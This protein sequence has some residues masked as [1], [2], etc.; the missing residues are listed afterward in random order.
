M[1]GP[2]IRQNAD[3]ES[4][5]SR[6]LC[7]LNKM[8]KMLNEPG[9]LDMMLQQACEI[10]PEAYPFPEY[11]SVNITFNDKSYR[12][13]NYKESQWLER[14]P[15]E[16]PDH[17]Q[18]KLE[19]FFSRDFI[20]KTEKEFLFGDNSFTIHL[21]TL[22]V[23]AISKNHLGRLIY[24]HTERKKELKG[25]RRTAE[26]LKKT[27]SLQESLQEVC[28]FLPD[29]WQFPES[30]VAR[31][32]FG[33]HV[34]TS[35]GF[36]ETPWS[37]R[38]DFETPDG[39]NGS[40]E[41][42]YLDE[43]PPSFE[44]PFLKEERDLLNN[45]AL[46][47]SGTA[48]QRALQELLYFNTERLKELHGLNETSSILRQGRSM[49]ESLQVICSIL[50]DA[51]QYPDFTVARITYGPHVFTSLNFRE[52][53]WVQRQEIETPNHMK[54]LIEVFYLKEFSLADE[55]PFLRE[56]RNMLINMAGLIT[57]S[58]IKR[59]FDNLLHENKERVKELHVIN[60]TSEIITQGMPIEET[61]QKI[62]NI[63]HKSWQYPKHTAVR[64]TYEEKR[65]VNREFT[66]TQWVQ[67][68]NFI[69]IDNKKGSIEVF[70]LKEFPMEYEGPF[71]REERQLI[72]N[73]GRLLSGYLNNYKGREIYSKIKYK[74]I[75]PF[76]PEE[77][78]QSLVKNKQPL[79]LFFNQQTLD[80]YIYLDMMKYKVKEILFVATLY[81][82]FTLEK[83]DGFFEQ[84]M[85]IIYQYSLF[86][87][88]RI[89]GVTSSEEALEMLETSHFDL[90]I[91]MVGLDKE[92]PVLIS[93]QIKQ[94]RPNLLIYML[95]N[96]KSNIQYYEELVP[97]L[98][99]VD[100]LFVW[101][102]ASQIFFAI[103]KS[104]E[105]QANVEND[106]RIG[107]VRV[108]LLIEDSAMYY[109][110]YLQMLYSIVFGQVQQV[111][112]EVEKNELDKICRMRS[113]PKI[114]LARNYDD[115]M[116]IFEKYKDF[117][118]CVISDVEFERDG[119]MDKK[120]GIK[121]IEYIQSQVINLPIILQSSDKRN[122]HVA[123]KLGVS[124][125]NKNSETLLN[126][127]KNFLT[128]YLGFGDFIFRNNEGE[129]IAVAR[130]L[131]EFEALL[132]QVSDESFYLHASENQY[133]LWLMARGEI[134]LARTLNPLRIGD[135]KDVKESRKQLI[136]TIKKYKEEKKRGKVLGFDE[137]A[138]L[139]E[140]N[141]VTFSGGSF[142]G[143]GRGLAF[144]N[145]LVYNLDFSDVDKAINIRTPKTVIIGTDEF[146]Y[147]IERNNLLEVLLN[148]R[149]PYKEIRHH[150]DRA[151]LSQG[152]LRKLEFFIDQV[153]KPIAVRS[154]SLSEDSLTQPFAGIF[155][156]YIIPNTRKDKKS[157]LKYL[158]KAIKLVFASIYSDSSKSYFK[159][160]H[161]KVEEEKM[162][163]VLQELVGNQ[164]G[165]FYYPHISGVAQSYNY[166]PVAH[167]KPEEGFAVAAVG[168][169]SY[170]VEGWKSYRFSPRY[171]NIEMYTTKDLINSSQVQ[172]Y[173]LDCSKKD[174]DYINEGELASLVMLEI[175]E[176]EKHGTINHCVSVYNSINDQIEPG[177]SS[178]G[179]RIV[180]FADILKYKH[181]PLSQTLDIMLGTIEE[182]LGSPVEIE[183]AVDLNRTL[184]DLP[185][186]YLLQIKPLVGNQL[187]INVDFEKLD[188]SKFMLYTSSSLGNG[189]NSHIRDVIFIDIQRF[190]KLKTHE[191]ASEM[192]FINN[193]MV[194]QNK[195]YILIG[196]GRWGTRDPF[197]G[198]PVI[199]S[200][201]SNAKVIV[202]ISLANYPLD[203]SLGSHFFHNVTSMNIGYF[204]V[205]DSSKTD[206]INWNILDEQEI[207][208]ETKFI[209]HIRFANPLTVIMSGKKKTAAIL[210]NT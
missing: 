20:T 101:S 168:L 104:I 156:T 181:I 64:I 80:K 45:L 14:Q 78:R 74:E 109:S 155:D 57:G 111:L 82:A 103:V 150:F 165:R 40:I 175:S 25:I 144:I 163:I 133:S 9:T 29:A 28:S 208:Q 148:P 76:K 48:S 190:N 73:I 85:G 204:S 102:G 125:L 100:K 180:N 209:K 91:I 47:I 201:I 39:K 154:S 115:A 188:K 6:R 89:T 81:D 116:Y 185:S 174:V 146:D 71:L 164:Y 59:V 203:S 157:V 12:N 138:T 166:Y 171:P 17:L 199:W 136:D 162:A 110:K 173:A 153:E 118:L 65:Y 122:E 55:G 27:A 56:E 63:L 96:Y 30:T 16:T 5:D 127:L 114:L 60:Q 117:M 99:S 61:L 23:G 131:R 83:E 129:Q 207:I 189:E 169:G 200:Q 66:E 15:F 193:R 113:R 145:S 210:F 105:D 134:E 172:F 52:T 141:I 44:G 147:F 197:L 108:I 182:A 10:I 50:P 79:Q 186:F 139:D 177:L 4:T 95:L 137:T 7:A 192:E 161:H 98:K 84:F 112:P 49:E 176:A 35:N 142:G 53:P 130:S 46:L 70:Y 43:F 159:A 36:K 13:K 183:Y 77:Y 38:Q 67:R 75:L 126:D 170:V 93:E 206:F 191:M 123:K 194:K 33:D 205:L 11:V 92:T 3:C 184:K 149:I 72:I 18:G 62:A 1:Q 69:T 68:E 135:F 88:P 2:E 41:I 37:Q 8:V 94:K 97:T 24:D 19:I 31:I 202:E 121:F 128:Y 106:T 26:T 187:G 32:T 178:A 86:S 90:V 87:L 143:K 179:P 42:F 167:M 198:I 22:I 119:K 34:Y 160:I 51:Y 158:S 151:E 21:A 54:G 58:A 124:F 152:I 107:L 132:E 195:P 120:A 140:K 196:P